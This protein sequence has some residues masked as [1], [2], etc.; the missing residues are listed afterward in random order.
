MGESEHQWFSK[1]PDDSHVQPRLI[2]IDLKSKRRNNKENNAQWCDYITT[3]NS[4]KHYK[5]YKNRD[6]TGNTYKRQGLNV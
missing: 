2:I 4:D 1:L 3:W 6:N 5:Q